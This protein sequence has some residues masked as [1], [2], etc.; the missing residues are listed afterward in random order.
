M[1]LRWLPVVC[2]ALALILPA[3]PVL[4]SAT[5]VVPRM[6]IEE[7]NKM[8]DDPELTLID[9]RSG[10]DW[11]TSSDKIKGAVRQEPREVETWSADYDKAKTIVLYCA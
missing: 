10:S 8:L 2:L 6:S 11:K 5:K 1:R 3:G 7:L 4:A 9:V